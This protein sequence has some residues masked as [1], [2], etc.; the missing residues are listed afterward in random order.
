LFGGSFAL[1][2]WLF[3]VFPRTLCMP[4]SANFYQTVVAAHVTVV[5]RFAEASVDFH[6]DFLVVAR[7]RVEIAAWLSVEYGLGS[8]PTNRSLWNFKPPLDS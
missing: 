5:T 6:V 3:T 7:E 1:R 8:T 4:D 2:H